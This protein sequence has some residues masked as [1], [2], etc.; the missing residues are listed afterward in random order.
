MFNEINSWTTN[1]IDPV[2]YNFSKMNI[3]NE[4]YAANP[5]SPIN[6][7]KTFLNT[8]VT[9]DPISTKDALRIELKNKLSQPNYG[10]RYRKKFN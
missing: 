9:I 5:F 3:G 6:P 8:P 10:L 7:Q 4:G 1:E 2:I